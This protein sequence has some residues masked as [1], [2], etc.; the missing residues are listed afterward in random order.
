MKHT[1]MSKEKIETSEFCKFKWEQILESLSNKEK[2]ALKREVKNA[3]ARDTVKGTLT[4]FRIPLELCSLNYK[5]TS[6][7]SSRNPLFL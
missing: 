4:L 7:I 6:V 3:E 1:H 2:N 5:Y